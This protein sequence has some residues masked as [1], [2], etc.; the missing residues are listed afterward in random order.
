MLGV[1]GDNT[2]EA[3]STVLSAQAVVSGLVYA[4]ADAGFVGPEAHAIRKTL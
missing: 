3:L 4:E 2:P 1:Q